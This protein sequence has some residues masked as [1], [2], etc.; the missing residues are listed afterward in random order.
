MPQY[1]V[2]VLAV[3]SDAGYTALHEEVQNGWIPLYHWQDQYGTHMILRRKLKL[4]HK[5]DTR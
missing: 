4:S 3:D 2:L 1:E 5:V